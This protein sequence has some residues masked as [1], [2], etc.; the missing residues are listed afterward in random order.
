MLEREER[1]QNYIILG[2]GAYFQGEFLR[3]L[4]FYQKA[5]EFSD[6]SEDKIWILY[7]M[8]RIY[9]EIGDNKT[10]IMTYEKIIGHNKMEAGAYYGIAIVYDKIFD[11][12]NALDFYNKAI[13]IDPNYQRAYYYR[14]DLYD[15]LGEY[16]KAI[17]SYEK[18]IEIDKKDYVAYNNIASI[19]EELG[20]LDEA[21]AYV[22]KSLKINPSY[23]KSLY[24]LGVISM[25]LGD[26]DLAMAS[27]LGSIKEEKTFPL[28][29]L[30]ISDILISRKEY[31]EAIKI[32]T[33]GLSFCPKEGDLYY[34]RACSYSLLNKKEEAI[35]DLGIAIDL[36][37]DNLEYAKKDK[38][39]KNLLSNRDFKRLIAY[40]KGR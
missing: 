35:K 23:Y 34:N 21:L 29:Y 30:N 5:L 40:K 22:I 9:D 13:E 1:R 36:D 19:Y 27:Y 14:G 2:Q 33:E 37:G 31:K 17:K 8:A 7:S 12:K 24:N 28:P 18:A 10:S 4:D 11:D 25:G 38:D 32:L 6:T 16:K 20:Q 39:F 3:S 26:E 15:R